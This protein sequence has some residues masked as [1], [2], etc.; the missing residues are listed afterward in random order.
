MLASKVA[1]LAVVAWYVTTDQINASR[2]FL[3]SRDTIKKQYAFE[4]FSHSQLNRAGIV[5]L[6]RV[7]VI[8]RNVTLWVLPF[9]QVCAIPPPSSIKH[10]VVP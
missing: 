9:V 1:G 8:V 5:V 10:L 2:M 3:F 6:G 7:G 4:R